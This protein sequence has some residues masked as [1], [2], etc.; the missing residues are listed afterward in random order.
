[1]LAVS[2]RDLTKLLHNLNHHETHLL[3]QHLST[4]LH[5][6]SAQHRGTT[7]ENTNIINQ[8]QRTSI[9]NEK[10]ESTTLF[11]PVSDYQSTG[12]KVVTVPKVTKATNAI[13]G[14]INILSPEGRLEGVMSAAEI[15]AFRTALASM[16]LFSRFY[17]T[18]EKKK[19]ILIFG[20]GK[21]AEWHARL[22]FQRRL[23]E[24]ISSK[25]VPDLRGRYPHLD[26]ETY[27][28]EEQTQ[29]VYQSR[30][31][32]DLARSD[33]IFCCTPS[34]E[35]LFTYNDLTA[36]SN[37]RRF[38]SLIGS[39]KPHMQEIDSRTLLSGVKGRI[40][41]DS[42]EACMEEAGELIMAK[43]DEKQLIELGEVD[44][45][46]PLEEKE[47]NVIF[48]CVGLGIMDLVIARNLLK[49]ASEQGLGTV[50]DGF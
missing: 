47:G 45:T 35:P 15:T 12:F 40:Y 31:R 1:M 49:M 5:A 23:E 32:A 20:S 38:I 50:V 42:V 17:D 25:L 36:S 28:R 7:T 18:K 4:A 46:L 29:D 26:I 22:A 44:P 24:S 30:L 10:W 8:P 6:F 41:V 21:Q 14:V 37:K 27:S 48:K 19:K 9:I 43:V 3:L 39:Y 33:A 13:R 16:I 11:M 34:T 2:E